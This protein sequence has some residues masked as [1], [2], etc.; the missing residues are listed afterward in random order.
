[1]SAFLPQEI[2]RKKR[3]GGALTAEEIAFIVRGIHDGSL[4]EG[5]VASFAMTVFMRG[6]TTAERVALTLGLARSGVMLDWKGL[7]LQGPLLDKHSSGG[8]GDKVSLMLA[9]IVAAAGERY[10]A[11]VKA[12]KFPGPEHVVTGR[13]KAAAKPDKKKR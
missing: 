6:M 12:R 9:P 2:I 10:A 7:D 11:D 3:D 1:M 4:S 13:P 8:V 5:Q